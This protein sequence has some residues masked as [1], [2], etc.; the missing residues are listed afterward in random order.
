MR[1]RRRYG[2]GVLVFD[3]RGEGESEG[4]FN[5]F[6]WSGEADLVAAAR[7]LAAPRP[8]V[9]AGRVG[10]LGL[11][12]GGELLLQ[13]AAHSPLLHA[14]VADGAGYRSIR[15]HLAIDRRGPISRISPLAAQT[16]ATAVLSNAH[17]TTCAE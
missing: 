10:G 4:D 3:R 1:K 15:D 8:D 6:G 12:V 2:Y 11:S 16:A 17:T 13:T 5:S 7:W 14:V 9:R